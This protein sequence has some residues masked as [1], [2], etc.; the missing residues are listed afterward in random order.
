[1]CTFPN[2]CVQQLAVVFRTFANIAAVCRILPVIMK[3]SFL[4]S[5]FVD[6]HLCNVDPSG[7]I[8][9][10][11]AGFAGSNPVMGMDVCRL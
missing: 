7:R 11:L 9:R 2:F 1:M 6:V 10:W 8:G 5:E 3:L 4:A